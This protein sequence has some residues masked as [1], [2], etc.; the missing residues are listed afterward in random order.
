MTEETP[1]EFVAATAKG[2]EA[3]VACLKAGDLI[4]A[5][6]LASG[7]ACH[8]KRLLQHMREKPLAYLGL[9]VLEYYEVAWD[10]EGWPYLKR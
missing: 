4:A 6:E 3:I 8:A 10:A 1:L 2:F 7:H 5:E 9:G